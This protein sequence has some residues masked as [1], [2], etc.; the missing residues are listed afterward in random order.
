MPRFRVAW[1]PGRSEIEFAHL[2]R[3]MLQGLG[4]LA[5]SHKYA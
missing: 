5:I 4:V 1:I 2:N 3:G